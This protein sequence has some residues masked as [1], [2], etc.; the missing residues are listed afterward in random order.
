[1]AG[2]RSAQGT[3]VCL[4]SRWFGALAF[5]GRAAGRQRSAPLTTTP[6][7]S[8]SPACPAVLPMRPPTGSTCTS[9]PRPHPRPHS[10]H[11]HR[12]GA[13]PATYRRVAR[14]P[15]AHALL[16]AADRCGRVAAATARAP[17][18]GAPRAAAAGAAA[19]RARLRP[20]GPRV[21]PTWLGEAGKHAAFGGCGADVRARSR[22]DE[23]CRQPA[24]AAQAL[25]HAP[26]QAPA[27]EPWHRPL[28]AYPSA[29][30]PLP[31]P[32]PAAAPGCSGGGT[33]CCSSSPSSS[34]TGGGAGASMT[35]LDSCGLLSTLRRR[36]ANW[37][38]TCR[39]STQPGGRKSTTMTARGEGRAGAGRS[40]VRSGRA[41]RV[42]L[43]TRG[44]GVQ[45]G[46]RYMPRPLQAAPG[47]RPPARSAPRQ[48]PPV[49]S[50]LS[51]PPSEAATLLT[52]WLAAPLG[53]ACARSTRAT[54]PAGIA[55]HSPSEAMIRR[56]PVGG[57]LSC[58]EG[59]MRW[60]DDAC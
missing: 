47:P 44:R 8:C 36:P 15:A 6:P 18:C 30:A 19:A 53:V 50:S 59:G 13:P 31:E 14:H 20:Q 38:H 24:Q 48:R 43:P 45:I 51:R 10:S 17:V 54:R 33:P 34:S 32:Q 26:P 58:T 28:P 1:M 41:A 11:L 37:V 16:A 55:S 21:Q 12:R 40:K 60:D 5:G 3:A 29:A 7:R 9:V 39:K 2:G 46:E 4:P 27:S 25:L 23:C 35:R 57:S 42:G 22:G 52:A 56:A 49:T